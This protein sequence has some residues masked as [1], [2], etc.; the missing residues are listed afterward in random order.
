LNKKSTDVKK[1]LR[2]HLTQAGVL[3]DVQCIAQ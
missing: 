3:E 2:D 1:V